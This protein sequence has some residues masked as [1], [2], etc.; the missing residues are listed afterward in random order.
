MGRADTAAV[1]IG[2][3]VGVA[4]T[5]SGGATDRRGTGQ[6]AC[7]GSLRDQSRRTAPLSLRGRLGRAGLLG[8]VCCSDPFE[9]G[10]CGGRAGGLPVPGAGARPRPAPFTQPGL[11]TNPASMSANWGQ[12]RCSRRTSGFRVG[13]HGVYPVRRA[14]VT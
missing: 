11:E 5:A 13:A 9:L 4:A 12:R 10:R 7:R 14:G 3:G 8:C 6:N 2:G 1:A